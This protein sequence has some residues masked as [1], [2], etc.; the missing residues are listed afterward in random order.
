MSFCKK[1]C[2][3]KFGVYYPSA[4]TVGQPVPVKKDGLHVTGKKKSVFMYPLPVP[5]LFSA[6]KA[7]SAPLVGDKS[8][9]LWRF[10]QA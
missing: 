5:S 9:S 1:T 7:F 4:V 8:L 2:N 6:K 3:E 10:L